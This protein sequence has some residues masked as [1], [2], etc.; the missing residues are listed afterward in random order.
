MRG[1]IRSSVARLVLLVVTLLA[2]VLAAGA[3]A[4]TTV[5]IG[6]TFASALFCSQAYV[7]QTGAPEYVVP[8]GTWSITSW[9]T[10]AG[11]HGGSMSLMVFR[12]TMTPGSYTVVGES[13]VESLTASSL[14]TFTLSTP[15]GVQGDDLL[16]LWESGADCNVASGGTILYELSAPQPAVGAT[17]SPPQALVSDLNISATLTPTVHDQLAALLAAVTGV[18]PGKSLAEKVTQI[19]MYA[20][21]GDT[22]DA[23][24]K[25]AAFTNEVNAQTGKKISAPQA[26]SLLA[27]ARVIEAGL[28]C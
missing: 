17:V 3:S 7:V 11:P 20:D 6:Q 15:I 10:Y 19:Q 26:A 23:C 27:Q 18:G 9:S 13:P 21:A 14:N 5:T 4:A 22:A 1:L 12:P 8:S 16:G 28:G 2:M 24:S 25:L